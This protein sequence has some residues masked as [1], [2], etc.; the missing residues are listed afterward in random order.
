VGKPT[1]LVQGTLDL[2]ILKTLSLEPKHGW[3]IAKRIQQVSKEALQ[4]Q[5]GSLYPALYRLEEQGWITADWRESETGRQ[6]KFYSLTRAGRKRLEKELA[7]WDRLSSAINLV[8]RM[9]E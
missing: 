1:D 9:T 2:L 7:N 3:A 6:A 5:Q 4:V 8:V